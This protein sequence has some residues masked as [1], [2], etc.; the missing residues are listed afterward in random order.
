[1]TYQLRFLNTAPFT[2]WLRSLAAILD[3]VIPESAWP[4]PLAAR[5]RARNL[6]KSLVRVLLS[7]VSRRDLCGSSS[8]CDVSCSPVRE[9]K[10][11][12]RFS[13]CVIL[14]A[15]HQYLVEGPQTLT[16]MAQKLADGVVRDLTV[17]DPVLAKVR[18]VLEDALS[19]HLFW[20][21]NCRHIPFCA[22][23]IPM[24]L[25]NEL[26]KNKRIKNRTPIKRD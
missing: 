6:R 1:M 12:D 4:K 7:F 20:N 11:P 21:R 16:D 9:N 24:D 15:S 2:D 17:T 19:A 25:K 22:R 10:N 23:S 8:L 18:A 13:L 14:G 26:E 3:V 5:E